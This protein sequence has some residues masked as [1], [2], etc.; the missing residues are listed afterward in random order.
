M[1][2]LEFEKDAL[3]LKIF[4]KQI[5]F[6]MNLD[7]FNAPFL[8]TL[9][10]DGTV[11]RY[12][13]ENGSLY[14]TVLKSN[15]N[16]VSIKYELK[17]KNLSFDE[18][19]EK[20]KLE[21]KYLHSID[22]KFIQFLK[23]TESIINIDNAIIFPMSI[24]FNKRLYFLIQYQEKSAESVT[25]RIIALNNAYNTILGENSF[26]I[27]EISEVKSVSYFLKKYN[28][29]LED[30]FLM[31]YTVEYDGPLPFVNSG[32]VKWPFWDE[33]ELKLV[34]VE[35]IR[36]FGKKSENA[37]SKFLRNLYESGLSVI[38]MEGKKENGKRIYHS[39]NFKETLPIHLKFFNDLIE[40]G[41]NVDINS[42][43]TYNP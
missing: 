14:F 9:F 38:Y 2:V 23:N 15:K 29:K 6:S 24:F 27:D 34:Y 37:L 1:E 30:L 42:Y 8:S 25:K 5:I 13:P 11:L 35:A 41:I 39:I 19:N 22:Q 17:A 10:I 4:Q 43:V 32:T 20:I 7:S 12:I 3:N 31:E 21:I 36:Y 18:D 26:T 40:S 33:I 28:V 16:Y